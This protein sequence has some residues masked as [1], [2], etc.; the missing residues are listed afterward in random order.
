MPRGLTRQIEEL[1]EEVFAQLRHC[2]RPPSPDRGPPGPPF[3]SR[4]R[5]GVRGRVRLGHVQQGGATPDV[6]VERLKVFPL[7]VRSSLTYRT[8][9]CESG[10]TRFSNRANWRGRLNKTLP[11]SVSTPPT[12][13]NFPSKVPR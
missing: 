6:H 2:H 11:W 5:R 1:P 10:G 9:T 8:R 4:L 12:G 7:A 13:P 3:R